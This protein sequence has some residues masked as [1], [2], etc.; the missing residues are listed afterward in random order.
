MLSVFF[1]EGGSA[2][3]IVTGAWS[4]KAAKE[5]NFKKKDICRRSDMAFQYCTSFIYIYWGA[6]RCTLEEGRFLYGPEQT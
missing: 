1:S 5:V 6:V 3:Y 2:D 4:A